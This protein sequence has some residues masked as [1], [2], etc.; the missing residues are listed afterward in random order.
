M[1]LKTNKMTIL[2][3]AAIASF[4]TPF[5]ASSVNVALPIIAEELGVNAILLGWITT[6][7]LLTCAMLA[8]PLGRIA[9]IYGMKKIFT[10]GIIFFTIASFLASLSPCVEFLI[11]SRALQGIGSSMIFVTALAIITSTF[12][13]GEMGR[14]IGI[15]ISS[16]F[17]GTVVG[18]ILGGLL[19]HLLGWRSIFYFVIPLGILVTIL[20]FSK[21]NGR[22]WAA[23]K[24]EKL[25]LAG[26]FLYSLSLLLILT[27]FSEIIEP[28]GKFMLIS[29]IITL[30]G[31][32]IWELMVD[33]PVLDVKIFLKNRMFT[34]SNL[35]GLICFIITFSVTFLFSLY[36][37][38]IKGLDPIQAGLILGVETIFM[39]IMSPIS[40]RLS[41]RFQPRKIASLGIAITTMGL[42]L[43]SFFNA[44]TS[45]LFIII[46]LILIGLGSG[47][48]FT[49]N[50]HAIM[51]SVERKYFGVASATLST[52]RIV[53]QS[54]GMGMVLLIFSLYI[55][56]VQLS[57]QN[58]AQL[59]ESIHIN[60][61]ISALLGFV[62]IFASLARK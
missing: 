1:A 34:I 7:F 23:C 50:A 6:A 26:S 18:P 41:D 19:T 22:E 39:A 16:V 45:M 2:L 11:F 49:P 21:L 53:G 51:G 61:T 24:E 31:F 60:L 10:I 27:G 35:A 59:L 30:I 5:M 29:G 12:P 28:F 62:A 3:I 8:V 33:H 42:M 55:G 44:C 43:S 57:P 58:Y 48:F 56:E 36:L 47:L 4:L 37:Q 17:M 54:L 38:Y 32:V 9:D 40:G 25:D 14:A 15:N 52:M 20:V 13:P 46:A